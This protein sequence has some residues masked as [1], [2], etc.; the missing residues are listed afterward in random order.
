[1]QLQNQLGC[2]TSREYATIV[3]VEVKKKLARIAQ[4]VEQR[5]ENP[6]VTSSSLVLGIHNSLFFLGG[7]TIGAA[8]P[9]G[10]CSPLPSQSSARSIVL[11]CFY[12]LLAAC[13]S[14]RA[15]LAASAV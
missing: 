6:W 9:K 5:I 15:N 7:G 1:M 10:P 14:D 11:T 3:Y 12:V 2:N 8:H 4:S 13:T